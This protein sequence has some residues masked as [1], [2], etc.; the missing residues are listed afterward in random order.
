LGRRR[1]IIIYIFIAVIFATIAFS[2]AFKIAVTTIK[3]Q[4]GGSSVHDIY[5]LLFWIP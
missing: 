4:K 1:G 2:M 5:R 3:S